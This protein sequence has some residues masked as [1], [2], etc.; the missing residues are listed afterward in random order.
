VFIIGNVKKFLILKLVSLC[1]IGTCV[2]QSSKVEDF[3]RAIAHAEGFYTPGTIPNR[4]RNPGD[5]KF[6]SVKYP[7]QIGVGKAGHVIFRS[8]AAGWAALYHQIDKAM[9]GESQFYNP[10]MTFRQVAKKYAGNWRVWCSNVTSALG[11]SADDTLYDYFNLSREFW[12]A[13]DSGPVLDDNFNFAF[14]P[15]GGG[16]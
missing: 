10:A 4:Y 3:A 9:N 7:G 2:G 5:L 6:V 11:V 14:N 16:Q 8:E 1:L 12:V 15:L 13:E